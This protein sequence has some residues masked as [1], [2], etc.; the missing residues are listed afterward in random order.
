VPPQDQFPGGRTRRRSHGVPGTKVR[1][2]LALQFRGVSPPGA[3]LPP[4]RIAS[5][6]AAASST[7]SIAPSQL[8]DARFADP[9]DHVTTGRSEDL[10]I[11]A[12]GGRIRRVACAIVDLPQLD[13]PATPIPTRRSVPSFHCRRQASGSS[14][15][16]ER[17][18]R[19]IGT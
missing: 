7:N 14:C 19:G 18:P 11:T 17:P 2:A 15:K 13:S 1:L 6:I 4:L 9:I 8:K 10:L 5:R 12:G 3:S 16:R